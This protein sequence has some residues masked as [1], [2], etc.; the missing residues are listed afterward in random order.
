MSAR[1][2]QRDA[3]RRA[4]K[5]ARRAQHD[6]AER[7]LLTWFGDITAVGQAFGVF[8][9]VFSAE[10][11]AELHRRVRAGLDRRVHAWC[12]HLHAD[13]PRPALVSLTHGEIV[14][15]ACSPALLRRPF[16][17]DGECDLCGQIAP[18]GWFFELVVV[19]DL[20]AGP[21]IIVANACTECRELAGPAVERTAA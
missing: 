5:A 10:H 11:N 9:P 16:T 4:R 13:A 7:E 2:W 17:D 18:G 12:S 21:A 8:G 6:A 15:K 1:K 19:A 14:C 3:E 20:G